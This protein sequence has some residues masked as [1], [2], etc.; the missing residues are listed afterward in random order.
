[1]LAHAQSTKESGF[2]LSLCDLKPAAEKQNGHGCSVKEKEL[3]PFPEALSA[4]LVQ[5]GYITPEQAA[6]VRETQSSA[7]APPPS[8]ASAPQNPPLPSS[9][10]ARPTATN[11]DTAVSDKPTRSG[12]LFAVLAGLG[13]ALYLLP[14]LI[15][16]KRDTVDQRKIAIITVLL[17]WTIIGWIAALV[18]ALTQHSRKA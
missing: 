9:A 12:T 15:A 11:S 10:A 5:S 13:L 17:G 14:I 8:T 6:S 18:M 2:G 7:S 4:F 3:L 16:Y 1:M